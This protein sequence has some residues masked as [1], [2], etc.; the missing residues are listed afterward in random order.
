MTDF[1]A[2]LKAMSN[3]KG[4]ANL[5]QGRL[6]AKT[7]E[8]KI[9]EQVK[10]AVKQ[11]RRQVLPGDN[12]SQPPRKRPLYQ[13]WWAWSI[14][15]V[16]LGAGGLVIA[17]VKTVE[18]LNKDL[19]EMK[20]VLTYTRA[21]SMTIKSADGT[22]L[23]QIGAATRQKVAL[24]QMPPHLPEAFIASEDQ[25]FYQHK[26]VDYV[27][28]ARASLAN[29]LSGQVKEGGSTITQQLARIVFLDQERS[30][31]RKVREALLAQ[32]MEE[33]L[34]KKQILEQYLN[35]VYLG[36]GAYGVADAAW[37]FFSKPVNKLTLGEMA[38]IAGMAPAPSAYSP[39]V[40]P[41][42]ARERR[43]I[44][45][46]RMIH[47]GSITEAEGNAAMAEPIKLKPGPVRN[48]TSP[49][50][51]FTSYVQQQLPRLVS[52]DELEV[53]GL[54]I[55]TTL[56]LKWQKHAQEVVKNA[57][58][59]YGP[60]EAFEQASL[61][62]IDPRNGEIRAL[63]GG[64]DFD[65]SQFNRATQAQR[66]PGS[67]FKAFVYST[68]IA[69]GF[70]PYRGYVDA[71]YVVDGYEPHNYG[72]NY[73]GSVS[74]K[75]ALTSSINIVAVK[76]L[77]DVGFNPVVKMAQR[78]GIKSKL[79]PAYSLALGT[80]EV[81]LLELTSA[82]GTLANQGNH[83]EVHGITR[84]LDRFGKV[85]Y[86]ADFKAQRALDA[87]SAAIM[88]WM[89]QGVVQGGTG[90][91]ASLPDRAVAGKTGT[92]E[93]RRDLWFVGYI[94]Q[95]VTGVWLGN[96]DSSPTWGASSTAAATWYDYMINL[97]D[98]IPVEKFP[99]LPDNIDDREG[100]IK[101]EPVHPGKVYAAASSGPSR[102]SD[103]SEDSSRDWSDSGSSSE[104]SYSG[105]YSGGSSSDSSADSSSGGGSSDG[106]SGGGSS[107]GSSGGSA[108]PPSSGSAAAEPAVAEPPP[109]AAPP[110]PPSASAPVAEPPP[111][112][113]ISVPPPVVVPVQPAVPAPA[114]SP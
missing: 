25:G 80:S 112:A 70:S 56:N 64:D 34:N 51:Y 31:G 69:A 35:L 65:K 6:D 105:S 113:P 14:V 2:K 96:D 110:D 37:I 48:A 108:A 73:R 55:E 52:K 104:D 67:T 15:G 30:I 98:D 62:S 77:V 39:L 71:K 43:N 86:Q 74:M 60:G 59:N 97:V 53:G 75:D 72:K 58:A 46:Q 83:V 20:D 54:T 10:H 41:E 84:I 4:G 24:T 61:V 89:L 99:E 78:M 68:A 8:L 23:Q 42:Y 13:R 103:E 18:A 57:I 81:N 66:Q 91:S 9:L 38:L 109:A 50:P 32:K 3:R 79:L 36:S 7:S 95:L 82:Y 107:G 17:G 44:V 12:G 11:S 27:A 5:R 1:L 28:I 93:K 94:P 49:V 85:I 19:P 102:E 87:D 106:S 47:V 40:N 114:A 45:L 29:V 101:A 111:Q 21:G 22:V 26:G 76:T 16:G 100:S 88:T 63:V 33:E 90:G 92:S